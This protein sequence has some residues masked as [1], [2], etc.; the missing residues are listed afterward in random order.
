MKPSRFTPRVE[1]LEE[2]AVPA[3]IRLIGD[4]LY[5]SNQVATT[6]TLTA[7]APNTFTVQDGAQTVANVR[8]G[9]TVNI[10]GRTLNDN[11]LVQMNGN[12]FTGNF[13]INS[14]NGN[15]TIDFRNGESRGNLTLLTGYGDDSVALGSNG[16]A[17]LTVGGAIQLTDQYG[18]D[19]VNLG[20]ATA[21]SLFLGDVTLTGAN[22]VNVGAGQADRFGRDLTV[23]ALQ[24]GRAV[25]VLVQE[26]V[27][28][29]RN[30]N[31]TGGVLGDSVEFLGNETVN[32]SVEVN[33]GAGVDSV[34]FA[35][36]NPFLVAGN[37][38]LDL[39]TDDNFYDLD[40]TFDVAGSMTIRAGDGNNLVNNING[41]VAGDLRVTFGNGINNLNLSSS[42]LTVAG[43]FF[44]TAGNGDNAVALAEVFLGGSAYIQL[45]NGANFI[46]VNDPAVIG[47]TFRLRAGNGGNNLTFSTFAAPIKLDV[48]LGSGNDTVNYLPGVTVSG[49]IDGGQG[50]DTL[51]DF[52]ATFLPPYIQ[53]NFP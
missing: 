29:D 31:I 1:A 21:P 6:L 33:L 43:N 38:T 35:N 36:N 27:Q 11:I 20:N 25:T 44:Y 24:D 26:N 37:V 51:N 42:G 28:I 12:T 5:I 8:V 34:T 13:L 16:T 23:Q 32:G 49:Y 52:G 7:T 50:D 41:N 45:G 40:A 46:S 47:G 3:T 2:R 15:D 10:T 30:V 9:G 39:G 4:S 14:G 53:A 48:V 18:N 19:T 22:V 17:G